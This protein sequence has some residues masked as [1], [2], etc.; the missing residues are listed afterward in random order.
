LAHVQ[1]GVVGAGAMGAGIAQ[2]ALTAGLDVVLFDANQ[3]ALPKAKADILA[4]VARLAEKGSLAAGIAETAEARLTLAEKL[5]DLKDAQFVI[6]AIIERLDAKQGLFRDL[7]AIVARD[8]ILATNTS[9]L[10]CAAIASGCAHKDRICG[11]HFFNPVPLMKLVEV[12]AAPATSE[13]TVA[14]ATELSKLIGKTPVS[15]KDGPG[16]LVNLQGRAFATE[17][18]QIVQE[19]VTDFATLDRIMRNGGGFRMGPFELMDLTGID[20][21]FAATKYIYEGYQ[22][23]AR[24]KTTTLHELMFNAGQYGRKTGKG[25]FDYS[26]EANETK[27]AAAAPE[28]QQPTTFAASIGEAAPGFDTLR[29]HG[30]V[31]GDNAVLVSPCGEDA[32]TIAIRLGVDPA[33]LVALDFTGLARKHIT[34]M[35]PLGG[36]TMIG[37]VAAWLHNQGFTVEIIKDSPGFVLQRIIAMVANLGCE[38]AQTGIGTPE[39]IDLAMKLAQN[40]PRGPLEWADYIGPVQ[41]HRTIAN[42][43][44]IT[45]S[46]RYRPSLWLRR[47]AQ[48]GRSIYERD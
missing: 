45:G 5:G 36:T 42:I 10:S 35:A 43:Q 20:V 31:D 9:S 15:V 37:K 40:Y 23:D 46:D 29:Q 48:L 18:L 34:L 14:R 28:P 4:R 3:A 22:H 2:I 12:I 7:E 25:Y 8:A 32:A 41:L 11:L 39:D 13:S 19:G 30:L 1:I 17:A 21:N 38:L 27:P 26:A 47:R 33:K 44:A 6:E 16:F 24:L